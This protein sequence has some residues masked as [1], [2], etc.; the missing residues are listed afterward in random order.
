MEE[1]EI[2]ER[3]AALDA[4]SSAELRE[5]LLR[6]MLESAWAH[7]HSW[8]YDGGGFAQNPYRVGGAE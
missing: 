2:R 6:S 8:C 4:A 5:Y 3:L 7:G 1:N